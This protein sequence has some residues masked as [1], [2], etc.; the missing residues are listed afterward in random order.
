MRFFVSFFKTGTTI[1]PIQLFTFISLCLLLVLVWIIPS[2]FTACYK[3]SVWCT[4]AYWATESAGKIGTPVILLL[5]C[6]FYAFRIE[7]NRK[8]ILVFF[9]SF[10]VIGCTLSGI[11]YLNE[12]FTKNMLAIERP[13]HLYIV[14][15]H[16]PTFSLDTIYTFN[17]AGR[18]KILGELIASDT[19]TYRDFDQ[20][21]LNHWVE[22]AGYSFPSGH[23]FNAFLLATILVFSMYHS[24]N[25]FARMFYIVPF[26]WAILVAVSRVAIGA[27]SALDVSF[28]A[29]LG[30]LTGQLFLYIDF[31]RTIITRRI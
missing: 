21:V 13:S 15:H 30:S 4:I 1:K 5:T 7:S 31:T 18:R 26:C 10:L 19:I 17:E 6:F 27:H 20:R 22:E 24:R 28:G 16:K 23:S 2:A 3:D 14:T 25:R 8:K 9:S 29:L 12:H 11:A